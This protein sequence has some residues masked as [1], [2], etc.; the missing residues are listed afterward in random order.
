[1]ILVGID[2]AK[3]RHTFS[4][5]NKETGEILSPPSFFNNNQEGFLL[6]IKKLG[7]YI[8]SELLIGMEVPGI[9]T[10]PYSDIFWTVA[11]PLL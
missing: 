1:M 11:I 9:I 8:K 3:N 5:I 6:L 7:S 10:L 4:I 2:I